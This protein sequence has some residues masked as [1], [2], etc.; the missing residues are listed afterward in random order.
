[1]FGQFDRTLTLTE[2]LVAKGPFDW[3]RCYLLSALIAQSDPA[4]DP[5]GGIDLAA[6]TGFATPTIGLRGDDPDDD[7]KTQRVWKL[8]IKR[9]AE[10]TR[11]LASGRAVASAVALVESNGQ[12]QMVQWCEAI[13]LNVQA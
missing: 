10:S 5:A 7:R 8:P 3:D 11:A 13:D 6:A 12:I 1:M 4:Q 2:E 9:T